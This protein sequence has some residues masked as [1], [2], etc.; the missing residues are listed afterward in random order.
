MWVR[1]LDVFHLIFLSASERRDHNYC[2][3]VPIWT[4]GWFQFFSCHF[5]GQKMLNQCYFLGWCYKTFSNLFLLKLAVNAVF[6]LSVFFIFN[7]CLLVSLVRYSFKVLL[8][9]ILLFRD[10]ISSVNSHNFFFFVWFMILDCKR[11]V[12]ASVY[13]AQVFH[14]V[15]ILT[16]M[17]FYFCPHSCNHMGKASYMVFLRV[18]NR[19]QMANLNL[20][21]KCVASCQ[22]KFI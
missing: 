19:T 17:V 4:K 18:Q 21:Q 7:Q 3:E 1:I 22:L 11:V 15:F 13:R 10:K 14:S 12:T 20:A 16:G 8:M 5:V 2:L 9:L 6:C